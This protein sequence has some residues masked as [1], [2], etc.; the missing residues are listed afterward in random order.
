MYL[1]NVN[2][3]DYL[4]K[5]RHRSTDLEFLQIWRQI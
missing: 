1:D 4:K 3:A 5:Y 2:E